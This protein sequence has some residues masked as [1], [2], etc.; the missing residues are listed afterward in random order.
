MK[1]LF[2]SLAVLLSIL[3]GLYKS[4]YKPRPFLLKAFVALA[5]IFAIFLAVYPNIYYDIDSVYVLRKTNLFTQGKI[6]IDNIDNYNYDSINKSLD[7]YLNR[8]TLHLRLNAEISN[9]NNKVL[10]AQA[11]PNDNEILISRIDNNN[12]IIYYPYIPAIGSMVKMFSIHVPSAWVAVLAFIFS[13]IFSIK[14]LIKSQPLD[15]II[16]EAS[17]KWGVLYCLFA[18]V[19]GMIWAKASW[20][21]YWNWDPRETSI[22]V[23]LLIYFAYFILRASIDN[24]ENKAKLSAVYSIIAGISMPFFIF[25]LP[26]ITQGLHPGSAGDPSNGPI[27]T[28]GKSMLDSS[29]LFSFSTSIFAFSLLFFLLLNY[30]VIK[31]NKK[32]QE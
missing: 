16:A 23:L 8:D 12:D 13:L 31:A 6:A 15:D 24:Q 20:G 29:L 5:I 28:S 10:Y 27:I 17:A 22:F 14:F 26:R 21:N 1:L 32:H 2:I 19:T 7:F 9:L 25:V 11:S 4:I 18:T 3:I 30:S